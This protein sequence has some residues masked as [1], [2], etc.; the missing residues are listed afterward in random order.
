ML[1]MRVNFKFEK[2][3]TSFFVNLFSLYVFI[4]QCCLICILCN[5]YGG[6]RDENNG[7]Q[8]G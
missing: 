5:E 4:L 3:K 7:F 6:T 8:L 1:N 2:V